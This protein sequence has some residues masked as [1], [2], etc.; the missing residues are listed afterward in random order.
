MKLFIRLKTTHFFCIFALLLA[1]CSPK[2]TQLLD[3]GQF[4]I[5]VPKH[6]Q[7]VKVNGID[8]YVGRIKIN[9]QEAAGFDLGA[10]SNR[11]NDK[12]QLYEYLT[13]DN[14][15][16]KIVRPMISGKGTTGVY[17]DSIGYSNIGRVRFQL[18]GRNL[19]TANEELL[20]KACKTLK[21]NNKKAD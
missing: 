19:T 13:I 11:L 15:K 9:D 7:Q 16:A 14:K 21:F 2:A 17:I 10:Y 4:T 5:K 12:D 8:S 6:W 1:S 20:I 18:S 3:F